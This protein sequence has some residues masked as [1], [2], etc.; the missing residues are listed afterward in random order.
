[1]AEEDEKKKTGEK[2]QEEEEEDYSL[3]GRLRKRTTHDAIVMEDDAIMTGKAAAAPSQEQRNVEDEG[4]GEDLKASVV[5]DGDN[6]SDDTY[7]E[8]MSQEMAFQEGSLM[9]GATPI[10]N[11]H[12]KSGGITHKTRFS[13]PTFSQEDFSRRSLTDN[14]DDEPMDDSDPFSIDPSSS[15][16]DDLSHHSLASLSG[17]SFDGSFDGGRDL[18]RSISH[19]MG[20]QP[21]TRDVAFASPDQFTGH[22][23]R[24]KKVS[25]ATDLETGKS[26]GARRIAVS[27]VKQESKL[28]QSSKDRRRQRAQ[29]TVESVKNKLNWGLRRRHRGR[30]FGG[31]ADIHYDGNQE[32]NSGSDNDDSATIS[33]DK[34]KSV[35]FHGRL[36]VE[37][38]SSR[39]QDHY[40][41]EAL[42]P[43]DFTGFFQSAWKQGIKIYE[44]TSLWEYGETYVSCWRLRPNM[45]VTRYLFWTFRSS[46]TAF[47]LSGIFF[48]YLL[49]LGFAAIILWYGLHHSNCI[50]VNGKDFGETGANFMDAYALSWTT[51]ST[52]GYGLVY[53]STSATSDSVSHCGMIMVLMT[54]E[55]FVGVLFASF[56]GAIMFAKVARAGSFAQITFSD[57]ILIKY[58]SGVIV[59]GNESD[60]SSSDDEEGTSKI[61]HNKGDNNT[62]VD[63]STATSA[64]ASE[65]KPSKLPCPMLEFRVLNRLHSQRRGEI[66]DASMNIVASIDEASASMSLRNN[67]RGA[68]RNK[69]KKKKGGRR[70][71][72]GRRGV[73]NQHFHIPR[74]AKSIQNMKK[75]VDR[76][77]TTGRNQRVDE[78][79]SGKLIPK[80]IFAKLETESQEHPF[81]K[82]L[83]MVRH[84]LDQHSPLLKQD[85]KELIRMNG[86]HWPEEL[87]SAEGVRASI[88][89][90]QI[91]VS[92]TGTSNVDA[93][94]VYS[95]KI[96]DYIDL[97]IGYRF[98]N[99]LF[100]ERDGTVG[101]DENLLNDVVEQQ[102]GGGE[103]LSQHEPTIR[104]KSDVDILI[105]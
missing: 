100:R 68:R 17:H 41:L 99:I 13:I 31:R 92:F 62:S 7:P 72:G 3:L 33:K 26:S 64:S 67:V 10:R 70:G 52:V 93:N 11:N 24:N 5:I 40:R 48:F 38:P 21:S 30:R 87:N 45:W 66:I 47:F 60:S 42:G 69:R 79:P 85:A 14:G 90:D 20:R 80:R 76:I 46:F 34:R 73:S 27:L 1:M 9:K 103:D 28:P 71:G 82:R 39:H 55:A 32:H 97:V 96:Y 74:R 37:Q 23:K 61:V 16:D 51:F 86:G 57:P 4:G 19:R 84:I 29:R 104:E 49:T 98:C 77:I 50:H 105:L 95:Q 63:E 44:D 94:S 2:S 58:G 25:L 78:D 91:L 56:M 101:V 22:Y 15:L 36:K 75:R 18:L 54:L 59:P 43:K 35:T 8:R 88:H 6:S 81:F 12:S 65:F 83:W 89:F 53:P 102:G